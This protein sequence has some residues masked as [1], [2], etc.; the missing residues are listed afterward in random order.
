MRGLLG[1]VVAPGAV[2]IIPIACKS[3]AKD[4]VE[5][6]FDPSAVI[7]AKD[8]VKRWAVITYGGLICQPLR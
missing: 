7:S 6:L 4:R 2:G 5:G 8:E 3:F 1:D